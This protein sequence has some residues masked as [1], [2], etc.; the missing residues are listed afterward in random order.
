MADGDGFQS[1]S[2]APLRE[3]SASK[4]RKRIRNPYLDAVIAQEGGAQDEYDD[5]ADFIVCKP[6][7]IIVACLGSVNENDSSSY[8]KFH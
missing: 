2:N 4:P 7:A 5:M 3:N 6:G 1:L 8:H